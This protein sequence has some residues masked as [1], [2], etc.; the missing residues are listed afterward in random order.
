MYDMIAKLNHTGWIHF[1]A[2]ISSL[3]TGTYILLTLK[4]SRI[5]RLVG[6]V[7][8]ASMIVVIV[9]AFMIYRLFG[10]FGIFH[11]FALVST[12]ALVGGMYP[13]LKKNR[14]PKD[15]VQHAEVMGWSVVGLYCAFISEMCSRIRFDH[16]MIVLG[17][18]CGL[19]CFLG[20]KLIKKALSK[21]FPT[22]D[23]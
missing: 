20:S 13:M 18:G 5:H 2:S 22:V 15:L 11:V 21:Y 4:G 7:Y 10:G 14:R 8:T 23:A 12:F 6:Y 1:I 3:L 17:V 19:T 16:A 9:T